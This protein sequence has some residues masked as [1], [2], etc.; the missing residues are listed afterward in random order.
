MDPQYII[1][2]YK[3]FIMILLICV[4]SHSIYLF[5]YMEEY[6]MLDRNSIIDL[7]ALHY[8]Y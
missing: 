3:G 2:V 7:F 4:L 1:S 5:L 8:I 6:R